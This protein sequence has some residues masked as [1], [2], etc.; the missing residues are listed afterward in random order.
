MK[1]VT[2]D[3]KLFDQWLYYI[4][5]ILDAER[6]LVNL[7]FHG[8]TEIS[9]PIK[10]FKKTLHFSIRK[11]EIIERVMKNLYINKSGGKQ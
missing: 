7:R 5:G 3:Q 4:G 6:Y 9:D 11:V 10:Q 8:Y 2:I 1:T